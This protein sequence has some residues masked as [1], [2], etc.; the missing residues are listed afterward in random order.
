LD[1]GSD[2]E[3]AAKI[4]KEIMQALYSISPNDLIEC[5]T[6]V[7][8]ESIYK[9]RNKFRTYYVICYIVG[10]VLCGI[11]QIGG[12]IGGLYLFGFL[13][14]IIGCVFLYKYMHKNE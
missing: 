2:Y 7:V 8:D 10:V 13:F 6:D 9:E 11:A 5:W 3:S 4:C 12:D 1:F 14:L